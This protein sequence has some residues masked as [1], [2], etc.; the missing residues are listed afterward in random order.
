MSIVFAW[1]G[2]AMSLRFDLVLWF[3]LFASIGFAG[4]WLAR[5]YA[6]QRRLLDQPGE[7]RSH[8]VPTPR[9]GGIAIVVAFSIAVLALIVRQPSQIV[10]LSAGLLGFLMV[11]GIGWLDDHRPL[12]PWLRLGVHVVAAAILGSGLWLG[13][14]DPVIGGIAALLC[15][16]LVNVWNF[17]DGID[18]IAATQ[19]VLVAGLF[20]VCAVAASGAGWLALALIAAIC[21]FLP[22][23]L[24]KARLFL[25]DVGSGALGYALAWLAASALAGLPEPLWPLLSL[26]LSAFLLDA[27]LTLAGR[28]LRGERWWQPHVE[29][30]YQRWVRRTGSHPQITAAYAFWTA[31]AVIIAGYHVAAYQQGE[32]GG[33]A[34]VVLA[35]WGLGGALWFGLR[36]R[37]NGQGSQ[38]TS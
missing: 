32:A 12:S 36:R 19:A 33:I 2:S 1:G 11:A 29:H 15:L 14:L 27:G 10:S 34:V 17:M 18:G 7:R 21:G 20:G 25:G 24:P 37:A 3:G 6:L 23:N 13:G 22:F 16:V 28:V 35:W 38:H 26:P 5:R 9:G 8:A 4:A 31:I 30:L